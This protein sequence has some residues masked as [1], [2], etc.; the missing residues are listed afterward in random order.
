M[1]SLLNFLKRTDIGEREGDKKRGLEWEQ[2][3]N[4]LDESLLN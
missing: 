4:Q 1:A 2:E 3:N